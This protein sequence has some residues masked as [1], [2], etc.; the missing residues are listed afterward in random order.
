MPI[1]ALEI[2]TRRTSPNGHGLNGIAVPTLWSDRLALRAQRMTSSVIRE[3]LKLTEKPDVISFA[4]GLPAPEVFPLAEVEEA[5]GRVLRD[6]GR[7]ALQ[8]APTEGFLPLRELIVRH[9]ARYGIRVTPANVMITSGSQQGLDLVGKLFV[10]PGD[11]IL[12]ESPT[13]LGAL[14]AFAAYQADYLTVAIDDDGLD[15]EQLEA[16][17]RGGPK[18][19]YVLPNFQ[20]PSGV[21]LSLERRRRLVELAN[22]YGAPIVEDDPYGQL[23]YEGEHLPPLVQIDAE[24]H[25]SASE[26]TGDVLYLSTLSKTLA[27][28]LRVAWIVAPAPVVS[29]LVQMKQGAD[30]HSSTFC[31]MVAYEVA[32]DGFLDR[33]VRRI[34]EVYAVRRDAMVRAL[35]RHMPPGVRFTKPA[36]GLFL[37]LTLP[38]GVDSTVL[39]KDSLEQEKV[40]FVPGGSFFPRGGGERTC[41]LNFSYSP[42]EAIDEGVRRLARSVERRLAVRS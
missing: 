31:Q 13:Y 17:L 10:N 41:R 25:D 9:M 5:A 36:G 3:L 27:P 16:Q 32:R 33:H 37:W 30:L 12:T 15:V 6:H 19:L 35:E 26:F 1:P 28:G 39:L 2:E 4:G 42:P 8:Y 38:E 40:A 23:R 22:H 7:T 11:R 14:Q 34:R 18:F 29:R 20:N 21:T 24:M